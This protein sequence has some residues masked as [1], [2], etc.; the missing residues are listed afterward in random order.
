MCFSVQIDKNIKKLAQRFK[1]SI[2]IEE[3]H[4]LQSLQKMELTASS[5]YLKEQLGLKR[6]PKSSIFKTP[7]DDG[8]IYPN[9][10]APVIKLT[11]G[12][13]IIHPMRYRI[14]PSN[15][16]EEIPTKYNVFN[17]RIDSLEKRETWRSIFLKNHG[18]FPF[19][20]F[21]E[22]VPKDGLT[23]LISFYPQQ[24]EMMW[25]PCLWDYWESHDKKIKFYS[26]ALITTNPPKSVEDMGHDRCPIFL[27]ED[28]IDQWLA[29]RDLEESY[30]L[31][32][33]NIKTE[34]SFEWSA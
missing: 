1:T 21:Y 26:F 25:A 2:A 6:K 34:Y 33:D 24:Y 5:D 32:K 29:C 28:N 14:R 7:K 10:F 13:R 9:Y 4:Y 11:Q 12:K 22:H 31:L 20:K 23:S 18:L 3:F 16:Q 27:K 17:A 30:E 8:L 19:K 15:S